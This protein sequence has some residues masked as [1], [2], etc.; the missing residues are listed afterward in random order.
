LPYVERNVGG[1]VLAEDSMDAAVLGQELRR[2][3]P[4]LALQGQLSPEY[5]CIIWRVVRDTPAGYPETVFIWHD[6][7]TGEPYPLS[8]GILDGFDRHDRNNTRSDY[9]SEDELNA[10]RE[11]AR[12]RQQE[13]DDEA[14]RDDWIPKHGR[15]LLPR[16]P[17]LVA[18]RRRARR[19]GKPH[20]G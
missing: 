13:R 17:G 16:T 7:R 10:Q 8:S 9:Q 14:L 20:F 12:Q 3:D 18:S 19:D 11:Q 1:I 2:R 15:P 5:G 6:E 4:L